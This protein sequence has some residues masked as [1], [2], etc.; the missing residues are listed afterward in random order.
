ME[1]PNGTRGMTPGMSNVTLI[2]C[3]VSRLLG[4]TPH[5]SKFAIEKK[6][7]KRKPR[8]RIKRKAKKKKKKGEAVRGQK[9]RIGEEKNRKEKRGNEERK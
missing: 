5:R 3:N 8:D 6:P 4:V 2:G 9:A 1:V 7:K